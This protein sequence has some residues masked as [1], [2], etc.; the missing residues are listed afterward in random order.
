M[1][2]CLVN[3]TRSLRPGLLKLAEGLVKENNYV[4][5]LFPCSIK[6]KIQIDTNVTLKSFPSFF[7]TNTKFTLP[8]VI[9]ELRLLLTKERYDIIHAW[10]Y[11]YLTS[12]ISILAAKL[13]N[14]PNLLTVNAFP[15]MS[16][17][18]CSRTV[19]FLARTYL[20]S[21]GRITLNKSD[22]IVLMFSALKK[23]VCQL[24]ISLDKIKV[25]PNSVDLD[26]FNYNVNAI[27]IRKELEIED[28][29]SIL[30]VGRLIPLKGLH[31]LLKAI[32]KVLDQG[33]DIKLFIVGDGPYRLK[34]EQLELDLKENVSFLGFRKD[35][36]QLMSACDILVLPSLSEGFSNVILEAGAIGK[37]VICSDVGGSSEAVLSNKTGFIIKPGDVNELANKIMVLLRSTKLVEKMGL[38]A[39]RFI[40]KNFN[41]TIVTKKY[42]ELYQELLFKKT[43]KNY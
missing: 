22:A 8:S 14:I 21:F 19:D 25:I 28:S 3:P 29:K 31:I 34:Y 32:S 5:I 7:I 16:W 12:L 4:D 24:D 43:L 27:K 33:M 17:S 6:E 41:T 20:Y 9:H 37:P 23:E 11:F 18:Y 39:N 2:I 40:S 35:I 15:G 36:P 38:K 10:D 13:M 30:F 26:R 42:L 1:R